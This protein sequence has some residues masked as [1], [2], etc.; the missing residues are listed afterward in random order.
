MDYQFMQG[1]PT[2]EGLSDGQILDHDL[3]PLL[4][5]IVFLLAHIFEGIFFYYAE[6]EEF[7]KKVKLCWEERIE[8]RKLVRIFRFSVGYLTFIFLAMDIILL[9]I[10]VTVMKLSEFPTCH[11]SFGILALWLIIDNALNILGKIS[12]FFS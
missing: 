2:C 4:L 8:G 9:I 6:K 7:Q 10:T 12:M 11:P 5:T 3:S 1:H